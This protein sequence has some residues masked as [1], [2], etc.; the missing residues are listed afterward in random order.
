[1]IVVDSN[2]LAARNLTGT[3]TWLSQAVEKRDPVWLAPPLWRYEFQ[4]I[5]AKAIWARQITPDEGVQA[6]R[7]ASA[8]MA[9][10]EHEPSAAKVIDLT[11]RYR[12]TAY[13][14]NFIALAMDMEV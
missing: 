7:N 14:A 11:A 4:N 2:V 6:W 5:V 1:M 12:I 3:V 9:E 10:N 8:Q 13:D